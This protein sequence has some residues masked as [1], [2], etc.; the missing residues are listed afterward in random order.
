M[1][2]IE[3]AR[4]AKDVRDKQ[5]AYFKAR[6]NTKLQASKRAERELDNALADIL[7]PQLFGGD[8]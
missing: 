1:T 2:V 6:D 4:L 8:R 5:K 3:L 7:D